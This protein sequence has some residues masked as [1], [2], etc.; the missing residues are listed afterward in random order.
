MSAA[1]ARNCRDHCRRGSEE[2][3]MQP[4]KPAS[5]LADVAIE[6]VAPASGAAST[7][8]SFC[9]A[10]TLRSADT[11]Q[12]SSYQ[13]LLRAATCYKNFCDAPLSHEYIT[14]RDQQFEGSSDARTRFRTLNQSAVQQQ[15]PGTVCTANR[16]A[17]NLVRPLPRVMLFTTSAPPTRDDLLSTSAYTLTP[18]VLPVWQHL[19]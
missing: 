10:V 16:C 19:Q 17:L 2:P 12:N 15:F 11:Q 3:Q 8:V 5:A 18:S 4:P 9:Y 6:H 7:R 13:Y 14:W 1:A